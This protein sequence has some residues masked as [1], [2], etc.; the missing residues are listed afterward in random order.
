MIDPK[1]RYHQIV[2][3]MQVGEFDSPDWKKWNKI[4]NWKNYV[5]QEFK[6]IWGE[7]SVDAKAC[8]KYICE[9]QAD[10][11]EWD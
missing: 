4:H 5:P 2:Q 9:Q 7:L 6:E 1:Q 8:I 3:R 11:E 10:K